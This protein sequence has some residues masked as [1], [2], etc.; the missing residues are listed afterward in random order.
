MCSETRSKSRS[1]RVDASSQPKGYRVIAV[2]KIK[3]SFLSFSAA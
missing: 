3:I 2:A 1:Q